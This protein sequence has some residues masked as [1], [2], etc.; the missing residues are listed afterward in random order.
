MEQD[1]MSFNE[2]VKYLE[3][4]FAKNNISVHENKNISVSVSDDHSFI[5]KQAYDNWEVHSLFQ[6]LG[7]N[8]PKNKFK[9]IIKRLSRKT[10][11]WILDPLTRR[12]NFFNHSIINW[13]EIQENTQND[14][15]H[16]L[17]KEINSLQKDVYDL[18]NSELKNTQEK[19]KILEDSI[20]DKYEPAI[21][22]LQE[23]LSSLEESIIGN[24]K[25]AISSL[26]EELTA[27]NTS[28]LQLKD[29]YQHINQL[30]QR[31]GFFTWRVGYENAPIVF[32]LDLG[33]NHQYNV[34]FVNERILELPFVIHHL[35]KSAVKILD[36]GHCESYLPLYL[37]SLGKKVVGIDIREYPFEHPNL[38]SIKGDIRSNILQENSFDSVIALSTIEHIGIASHYGD[39]TQSD[40]DGDRNAILEIYRLLKP[41][42]QLVLTVP[43][44]N[45][46]GTSW[47][48]VY[49]PESIRTL[50][51]GFNLEIMQHFAYSIADLGWKE[52]T[53]SD[54]GIVDS[55]EK[56]MCVCLLSL[57]KPN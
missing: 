41:G 44:G 57:R 30:N 2:I 40:L 54:A 22:S 1:H 27:L 48:R 15:R 33:K 43:F 42:G 11:R 29:P 24:C 35:D 3:T 37:A 17:S 10:M 28:V 5:K 36:V 26:Q 18:R 51:N 49:T 32:D 4:E 39:R 9:R 50:I 34:A 45:G 52:V 25:S 8:P 31:Q 55:S 23:K 38:Y 12:I 47:Y 13:L 6:S 46:V 7:E 16:Q 14:L 21:S 19:L 20:I 53:E 56:T